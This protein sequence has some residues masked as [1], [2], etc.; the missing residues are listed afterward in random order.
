MLRNTY[1]EIDL[2]NIAH[3]V[4]AVRAGLREN[5]K[6]IAVVK[7]DAYGHGMIQVGRAALAAGAEWL[8]V[9]MPEEGLELRE[10]GFDCPVLVMGKSNQA[11]RKLAVEMGLTST[12]STVDEI[13]DFAK[14]ARGAG[15][16]AYVH[17]KVD[18]G[19]G[20]IGV[21]SFDDYEKMLQAFSR[22][23]E[24]RFDG[25]FTHFACSDAED[26]TFT[27]QQDQLFKEYLRIARENGFSPMAHAS[28]S[29]AAI[30]LPDMNY[31]AIRLGISLYGY[32]P[33]DQVDS[34]RI[35]LIPVM[36]VW[37]EISHIKEIAKGDTVGYDATYTA[38]GP[39]PVATLSIGYGDGYNRLLSNK[40]RVIVIADGQACYANVIGRVCM[41]QIMI[42]ISNVP[43][44]SLG[45]R[46]LVMGRID[47]KSVDADE[48]ANMTGT[49][50]YEVLLSFSKRVPRLYVK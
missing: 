9:A 26:K 14:L 31:D 2:K 22:F 38:D 7:A 39:T 29:A 48:I 1:A 10:N 18:T 37:T 11:Q 23:K 6:I 12:V 46:V 42:D 43:K 19:M 28:N 45:D 13:E 30:D 24:V 40:G 44:A 50:S 27:V 25:I 47:G 4:R 3:N 33:S 35:H 49:I 32:Y 36:R 5:T 17:V 34:G 21:R 15:M 41:D 8:A 20:R 16:T